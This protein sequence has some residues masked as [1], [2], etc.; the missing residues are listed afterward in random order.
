VHAL[1]TI[2]SANSSQPR[3]YA[4]VG[5]KVEGAL[6]LERMKKSTGAGSP[7][8]ARCSIVACMHD[9]PSG[10]QPA[11]VYAQLPPTTL[12]RKCYDML[13]LLDAEFTATYQRLLV[14]SSG[15]GASPMRHD[16]LATHLR[17]EPHE[18]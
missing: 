4:G 6:H 3:Y 17:C 16:R 5:S 11:M 13:F 8:N 7:Q 15:A 12:Q 9:L 14:C 1:Q 10:S 18:A 2:Y